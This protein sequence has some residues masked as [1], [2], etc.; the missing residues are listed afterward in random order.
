MTKTKKAPRRAG[1]GPQEITVN[2]SVD[3]EGRLRCDPA[4]NGLTVP[5]DQDTVD[6]VYAIQEMKTG[7]IDHVK[8]ADDGKWHADGV[9]DYSDRFLLEQASDG[10]WR[11]V[12]RGT[13]LV[14]AHTF[15]GVD[16]E[17]RAWLIANAL[18]ANLERAA[19]VRRH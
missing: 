4:E 18:Y 11:A 17:P 2:I 1:G 10:T 13:G 16:C 14:F 19:R 9:T 15:H 12:D 3:K 5:V 7:P 6:E 8:R